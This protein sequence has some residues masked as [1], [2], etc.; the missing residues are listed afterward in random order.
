MNVGSDSRTIAL[1]DAFRRSAAETSC[2]EF[3]ENQPDPRMIGRLISALSN[4]ARMENRD[5][6]YVV[7]GVRD[8]DHAV[9]GTTFDP[10]AARFEGQ[11]LQFRLAQKL[12]PDVVPTFEV[13]DHPDGR[14]VLLTIPAATTG[15]VEL[16]APRMF[17]LAAPPLA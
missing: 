17:G 15:P 16:I 8:A 3:K 5:C 9:T 1:I 4:A 11:P 14:L 6:G 10:D 12:R 7:W 13:V 2:V